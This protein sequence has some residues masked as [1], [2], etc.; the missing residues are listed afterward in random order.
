[1]NNTAISLTG[2]CL[3]D[4][5]YEEGSESEEAG[6]SAEEADAAESVDLEG[7]V[8]ILCASEPPFPPSIV[9]HK[10]YPERL[11]TERQKAYY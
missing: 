10:P 3:E 6:E 8:Q 9:I 2:A 1:M 7:V 11:P 5:S 4:L